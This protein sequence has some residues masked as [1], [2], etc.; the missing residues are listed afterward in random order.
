LILVTGPTGSGKTTTLYTCLNDINEPETKIITIEDPVE[1]WMEGILQMQVRDE[2]GFRFAEALRGML[3]HDPDVLLVGEIRDI[4][5][6]EIAIRA[7]LTGHLVFATL[8]TNDAASAVSR[9][10]DLGLEP[11]LLASAL[12]GIIAQRLVRRI[13]MACRQPTSRDSLNE[14]EQN[15]LQK[16]EDWTD[17]TFWRGQGCEKC[18]F[19]GFAGRTAISEVLTVD[20]QIRRMIQEKQSADRIKQA[21]IQQ[22]MQTLM[23]TGLNAIRAGYTCLSEVYRVT[24]EDV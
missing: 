2:I 5:T 18:R 17:V 10:L 16:D 7:A 8:H 21:A 15:L 22:G 19:T 4:E 3:R 11:F 23:R 9:L 6:A 20:Q 13:C 12:R 1:Y 24:Q 14:F